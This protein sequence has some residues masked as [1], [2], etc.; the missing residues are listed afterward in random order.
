MEKNLSTF[1]FKGGVPWAAVIAAFVILC[2]ELLL[3]PWLL[4]WISPYMGN[5]DLPMW[6]AKAR[7]I[8]EVEKAPEVLFLGDS[9]L[10][11]GLDASGFSRATGVSSYNLALGGMQAPAQYFALKRMLDRGRRPKIVFYSPSPYLLNSSL[12]GEFSERFVRW[13]VGPNEFIALL[14]DLVA[15]GRNGLLPVRE[16]ALRR[17]LPTFGYRF[18]LRKV[19][20]AWLGFEESDNPA[21]YRDT[22]EE[23]ARN[24]GFRFWKELDS[25]EDYFKSH[26]IDAAYE[27]NPTSLRLFVF[28]P[29]TL[30]LLY[31]RKLFELCKKNAIRIVI[32][33]GPIPESLQRKRVE[34]GYQRKFVDF[35]EM[36][37]REFPEARVIEPVPLVLEDRLFVDTSHLSAKGAERYTEF[38]VEW[39]RSWRSS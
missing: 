20:A 16:Y 17:F 1:S 18:D 26:P 2:H 24:N 10:L 37:R 22:I 13:F 23:L 5:R 11:G 38:V 27:S 25:G 6:Q 35:I 29:H 3:F 15:L 28:E 30:N 4:P 31:L 12:S 8:S 32:G 36:L 34:I 7:W 14:P 21:K 9:K 33:I 19:F 39:F